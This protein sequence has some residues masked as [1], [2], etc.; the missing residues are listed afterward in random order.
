MAERLCR[1]WPNLRAAAGWALDRGDP[2]LVLRL[3]RAEL[4]FLDDFALGDRREARR[5]LDAGARRRRRGV[6]VALRLGALRLRP[7]VFAAVEG[8]LDRAEALAER[9]VALARTTAT[10]CARA[11]RSTTL[12]LAA[13]FRGD[14]AGRRRCTRGRWSLRGAGDR[15]W[16]ASSSATWPTPPCGRATSTGPPRW[17][18]RRATCWPRR[19]P[20]SI[21]A[22]CSAPSAPSPW[23]GGTVRRPPGSTGMPRRPSMVPRGRSRR[24][25]A[26]ALAGA[27]GRGP[28]RRG[29]RERPPGCW[30]RPTAM[31]EAV[32]VRFVVHQVQYERVLA[33]TRAS[34]PERAFAAAWEAG[35]A[36]GRDEAVAAA[37]AR[38]GGGRGAAGAS[39]ARRPTP[40]A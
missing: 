40:P 22:A 4:R 25:V 10:G 26:D 29:G 5:W 8:D 28:G 32:G 11:E 37:L 18:R 34:L 14:L 16:R 30:G 6:D 31:I 23:R 7:S 35:R 15:R 24:N 13:T 36:L 21:A 9:A 39:R 33:A 27:G 20:A 17:R 2:A 12:A 19:A 1:E 38:R 3:V